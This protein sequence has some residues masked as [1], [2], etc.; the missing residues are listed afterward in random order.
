MRRAVEERA[1]RAATRES[2][3]GVVSAVR[4]V[5]AV[6]AVRRHVVEATK[7]ALELRATQVRVLAVI[8][9]AP[10]AERVA[11]AGAGARPTAGV[12][13]EPRA[14]SSQLE[15]CDGDFVHRPASV[16]CGVPVRDEDIAGDEYDCCA[17]PTCE[18]D[19]DHF[20]CGENDTCE[21][22]LR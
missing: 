13:R 21:L 22:C 2:R 5:R 6:S 1:R 8:R 20:V 16:E 19:G 10:A 14:W 12:C 17:V 11:T 15:A 3:Q 4:A 18:H 9:A 7:V